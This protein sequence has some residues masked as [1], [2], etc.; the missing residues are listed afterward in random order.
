MHTC[1][2]IV[3]DVLKKRHNFQIISSSEGRTFQ[4]YPYPGIHHFR[5]YH[6]EKDPLHYEDSEA[7]ISGNCSSEIVYHQPT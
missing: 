6:H 2:A 1:E 5:R 3:S 4:S 7:I